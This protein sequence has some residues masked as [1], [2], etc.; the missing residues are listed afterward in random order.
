M[1][2]RCKVCTLIDCMM[3]CLLFGANALACESVGYDYEN[4]KRLC[5]EY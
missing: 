1:K 4:L 2:K 5:S 3:L